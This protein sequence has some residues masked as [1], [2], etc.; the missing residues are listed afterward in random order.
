[1]QYAKLEYHASLSVNKP[2]VWDGYW[3]LV[4]YDIPADEQT[5]RTEI[6]KY[7]VCWGFYQLHESV[8]LHA[9]PCEKQVE[10]LR[11][12]FGA[13][14]Y[15]RIFKVVQIENDKPLGNTLI[16]KIG[17][18]FSDSVIAVKKYINYLINYLHL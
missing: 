16:Y 3:R 9:Y 11:S 10:Y 15:L 12:I 17:K 6:K 8:Y 2:R 7:L 5:L 1:L 18:D 14:K 4:S 13:G